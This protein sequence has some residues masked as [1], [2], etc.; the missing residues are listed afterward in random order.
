MPHVDIAP[1]R[2]GAEVE[3]DLVTFDFEIEWP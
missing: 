3:D 1:L 2:F